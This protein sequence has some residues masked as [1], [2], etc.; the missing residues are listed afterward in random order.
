MKNIMYTMRK[1]TNSEYGIF[2]NTTDLNSSK[3]IN[4]THKK[5]KIMYYFRLNDTKISVN[6]MYK[7]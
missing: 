7:P 4:V 6:V 1:P 5:I 3:K 2:H